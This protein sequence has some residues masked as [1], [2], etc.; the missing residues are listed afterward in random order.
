MKKIGT[1]QNQ[2]AIFFGYT[3]KNGLKLKNLR[4]TYYGQSGNQVKK[5]FKDYMTNKLHYKD[6]IVTKVTRVK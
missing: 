4:V 5:L 6:V 2:Y 3:A 1:D